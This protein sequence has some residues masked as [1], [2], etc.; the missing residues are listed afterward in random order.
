MGAGVSSYKVYRSTTATT[1][2]SS[3]SSFTYIGSTSGTSYSDTGLSQQYYYYCIKACDSANSCSAVSSTVNMYP[4]GKYTSAAGLSSG[5]PVSS[6]PTKKAT[7]T[8]ATD[9]TAGPE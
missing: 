1:C 4:D 9:R 8:W 7:I 2:S 6:I 5:P 3:F